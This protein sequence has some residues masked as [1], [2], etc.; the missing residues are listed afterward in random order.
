M[1]LDLAVILWILFDYDL[2]VWYGEIMV[3]KMG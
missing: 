2:C 1:K 3:G